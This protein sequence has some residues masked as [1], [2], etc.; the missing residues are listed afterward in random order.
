VNL[1]QVFDASLFAE[2]GISWESDAT[3]REHVRRNWEQILGFV[4]DIHAEVIR[5]S[6]QDAVVWSEWEQRGTRRDGTPHCM[7]GVIL[8]G[9]E[10][11]AIAWARF[12]LEPV[13]EHGGRVDE[14]VRA[15]VARTAAPGGTPPERR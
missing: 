2:C 12:Y 14:A 13:Q 10:A 1:G 5:S 7:R 9:V 3:G 8:F 11:D 4:P 15:Q 6:V